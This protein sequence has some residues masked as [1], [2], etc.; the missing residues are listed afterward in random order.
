MA[1]QTPLGATIEKAGKHRGVQ[2]VGV[3]G[4]TALVMTAGPMVFDYLKETRAADDLRIDSAQERTFEALQALA[5]ACEAR[6]LLVGEHHE[7]QRFGLELQIAK[8]ET[9]SDVCGE[10]LLDLLEM[11][12]VASAG[13]V[14]GAIAENDG[15]PAS[16]SLGGDP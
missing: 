1:E 16:D 2:A 3:G 8:W 11:R 6:A 12:S 7:T 4:L 9:K 13:A 10:T 15:F 14:V 5:Q